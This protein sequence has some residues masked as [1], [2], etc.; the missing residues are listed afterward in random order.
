MSRVFFTLVLTFFS[1]LQSK[2]LATIRAGLS[3]KLFKLYLNRSYDFHLK[4]NTSKLIR[5]VGETNLII[6]VIRSMITFINEFLVMFGISLFV[7]IFQPK[8]SIIVVVII[9]VIIHINV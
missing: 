8:I 5:N 4:N 2:Y 3:N 9:I 1:F 6:V 7:I